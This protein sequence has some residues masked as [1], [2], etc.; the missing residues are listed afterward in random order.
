MVEWE[1]DKFYKWVKTTSNFSCPQS[2]SSNSKETGATCSHIQWLAPSQGA[3]GCP[4]PSPSEG[5]STDTAATRLRIACQPSLINSTFSVQGLELSRRLQRPGR[6]TKVLNLKK[7]AQLSQAYPE[8]KCARF[9]LFLSS[10]SEQGALLCT[11]FSHLLG[12]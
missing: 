10:C 11:T 12:S 5:L 8:T 7:V 1:L 9:S 2:P 6:S 4:G 3:L